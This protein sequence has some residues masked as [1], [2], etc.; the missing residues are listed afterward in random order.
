[1][2]DQPNQE[3]PP[4]KRRRLIIGAVLRG[5]VV[6]TVLVALYY[7]APLDRPFDTGTAV[8]PC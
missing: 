1:M 7:L 2:A 5:L 8:R 3:L 4:A 6:T